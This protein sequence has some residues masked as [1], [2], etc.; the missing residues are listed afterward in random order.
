MRQNICCTEKN[1][2]QQSE[3]GTYGK[4]ENNCKSFI[5]YGVIMPQ[6]IERM[7]PNE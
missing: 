4:G 7:T 6:A 2:N 5:W 1:K 3:K